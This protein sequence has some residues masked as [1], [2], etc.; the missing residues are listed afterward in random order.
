MTRRYRE[1]EY[2][3]SC[4]QVVIMS[5]LNTSLR[6]Q[7]NYRSVKNCCLPAFSIYVDN[8]VCQVHSVKSL[9][10]RCRPLSTSI[11]SH[12]LPSKDHVTTPV[13]GC[14]SK[15]TGHMSRHTDGS[16]Y[17]VMI[18]KAAVPCLRLSS[19]GNLVHWCPRSFQ[20]S[21]PSAC[22]EGDKRDTGVTELALRR[23]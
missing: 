12:P 17:P 6:T 16:R 21:C 15:E 4:G 10:N 2:S 9:G 1:I 13:C 11:P 14:G 8:N 22:A 20:H 23:I 3:T 18:A 7:D 19:Q 5:C